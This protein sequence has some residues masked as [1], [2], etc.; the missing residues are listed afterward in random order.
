[1]VGR[2]SE[3]GQEQ[4][5]AGEGVLALLA[6]S[7]L[8]LAF[9]AFSPS[10][11]VGED[12]A[13][14]RNLQKQAR[15]YL[16]AIWTTENGLPQNTI[17][18]IAQTR[19]GY[20]WVATNGGLARFDG[21]KFSVYETAQT[22]QL[23]SN[24]I[25]TL[26]EDRGGSLWIGTEHGGLVKYAQGEFVSFTT[27]EGLPGN[28]IRAVCQDAVG[29]LWI[30]TGSGLAQFKDGR[31]KTYTTGDGIP[32]DSVI[33]V[34]ADRLGSLWVGTHRGLAQFREGRW[35][36]YTLKEGLPS[37][38]VIRLY[39][40]PDG[41]LWVGTPRGLG[42]IRDGTFSPYLMNGQPLPQVNS[43]IEDRE[44]AVWIGTPTGIIRHTKDG[45]QTRFT[46]TDGLSD[47]NV[48][49]LYVDREGSVWIGTTVGGLNRWAEASVTTYTSDDGLSNEAIKPIYQ[50]AQGTI[51]VGVG[52]GRVYRF[53]DGYLMADPLTTHPLP[54]AVASLGGDRE[55]NL[56]IGMYGQGV[57]R[58]QDGRVTR[59]ATSNSRLSSNHVY[60][61]FEDRQGT[62]W[63]GTG[64]GLHQFR[65]G[66]FTVYRTTDGLAHDDVRFIMQADDGALWIGTVG[67]LSRFAD[68][69]FTSFTTK[70][71]L[72]DN[73]VRAVHQDRDGILWI[74]TYGG[75]LNR[76]KGDQFTHYTT[77]H[78][79]FDNALSRIL[80]DDRGAL[81]MSSNHGIFRVSRRELNEF[82]EGKIRAITSITYGVAE[83]MKTSECNGGFQPAGW[84]ARD[85]KLWFPTIQGIVVIDPN[86]TNR[87]T[88]PV[89][90]E[91]VVADGASVEVWNPIVLPPGRGDVQIHY[92]GLSF[93][94][95][96]KVRFKYQ[97]RGYDHDWVDAGTR[98]AAY[99]TNLP[100][101]RYTFQVRA[102]NNDGVWNETGTEFEFILQP[103]FH[104]TKLFYVLSVAALALAGWGSYRLRIK[105][106]ERRTR[107]LGS[108]VAARTAEVVEQR[109]QLATANEQLARANEDMLSVFE[110]LR[111]GVMTTD[112]DG[113]VT[114]LSQT[115]EELVGHSLPQATGQRWD[116]VL[117]L[118]ESERS[119]LK[120]MTERPPEQRSKCLVHLHGPDGQRYCTEVEIQDDPRDPK[121]KIFFLYDVTE[122]YDLRQLLS[123]KAKLHDLVGQSTAMQ[124][125]YKQIHDVAG[126]GITVLIQGETGT[127]KELVARAIHYT[128]ARKHKP[129][130]AVNCAGLTESLLA[131][132]LFGHRKGAFTGAVGDQVGLFEAAHGG[133][134][135]LDEIGDMPLSVQTSLLRVLQ[136]KEITRVGETRPR[137][138]D[139]RI[140]AA[141]HQDLKHEIAQGR[142]REDLL[143]RIRGT[144]IH[145]PPLRE[146]R[147]DILWL[148]AWFLSQ[149]RAETD[150]P[151]DELS[152]EAV[153][154]LISYDWPGNVRELKSAIESAA[155]R[156]QGSVIQVSDL[157]PDLLGVFPHQPSS[158]EASHVER[159]RF[160]D[161]LKQAGGNRAAAARLLGISRNTFYRRLTSLGLNPE[162]LPK[163]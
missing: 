143:Y 81:W 122:V 141:T 145:I 26:F 34:L 15:K 160:L 123:E 32:D 52:G 37:E 31:F 13:L 2:K 107:E 61:V 39:E 1:M 110:Q 21:V 133:T 5:M 82:A 106:L 144:Q 104:Q 25:M 136:E 19:D 103:H 83:G 88:P 49:A 44:G 89:A 97:L 100:P 46:R 162:Q 148:V 58:V 121:R 157:P 38:Q 30:G 98:R 65:N 42:V 85:G 127:G 51:W 17:N 11:V 6:F 36:V 80:E 67:G 59:Y 71:G 92:T 126:V 60:A 118:P 135:F 108:V 76:L 94:A 33:G 151:I 70:N 27:E 156:C 20:I 142:F 134:L 101:G 129:F 153:Q 69:R 95:P 73:F 152:R 48:R 117:P 112:P 130:I 74:G 114:F 93:I 150:L 124:M 45:E 16:Q 24:R 84:K 132:Q 86:K 115:A 131:S 10:D 163:L 40:H 12:R 55:G 128:S 146:R 56:W 87:L 90:V 79:L 139:V 35:R 119:Q 105:Q 4:P 91:Q 23:K 159:Q 138:I 140:I 99:Y 62:L 63:I 7:S 111:S 125:V 28:S 29:D 22:P 154:V 102:S 72:S 66:A 137:P 18:D 113:R 9:L 64:N 78:G 3:K 116:Q 14:S 57:L 96:L 8:L 43:I 75:G 155:V 161:A 50:D 68:G 53:K 54:G 47:E 147:E 109:N 120:I 41:S 77:K 158:D 149:F